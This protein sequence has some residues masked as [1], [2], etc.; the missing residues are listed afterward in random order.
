MTNSIKEASFANFL[1]PMIAVRVFPLP[2]DLLRAGN[3]A[4]PVAS[5]D[6]RERTT[7]EG[8]GQL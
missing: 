3:I 2:D 5:R 7:M 8:A 1:A 4:V 6:E